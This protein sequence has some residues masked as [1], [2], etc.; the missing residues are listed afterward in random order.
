MKTLGIENETKTASHLTVKRD[1]PSLCL[2]RFLMRLLRHYN[3]EEAP[4]WRFLSG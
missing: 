4:K 1:E 2:T 3:W